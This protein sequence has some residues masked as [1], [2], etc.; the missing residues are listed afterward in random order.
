MS[1]IFDNIVNSWMTSVAGAPSLVTGITMI[2]NGPK[3]LADWGTALSEI[4]AGIGL[5]L[6]PDGSKVEMK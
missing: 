6:A 3:T 5:L 2:I 4:G 1:S